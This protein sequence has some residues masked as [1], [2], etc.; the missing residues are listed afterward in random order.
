MNADV[1]KVREWCLLV[2]EGYDVRDE[3]DT[4]DV[5]PILDRIE[6]KMFSLRLALHVIENELNRPLWAD[7]DAI[8]EFVRDRLREEKEI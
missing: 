4:R 6:K 8:R 7:I 3:Y 5:L 2:G 1:D